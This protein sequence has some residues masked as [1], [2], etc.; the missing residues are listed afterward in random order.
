METQPPAK[1]ELPLFVIAIFMT[2]IMYDMN[3]KKP[4]C[5]H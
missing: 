2:G 1:K 3:S 4:D 5:A